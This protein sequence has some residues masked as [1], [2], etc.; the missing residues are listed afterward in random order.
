MGDAAHLH[1]GGAGHVGDVPGGGI[2]LYGGVGGE[3]Q[4]LDVL[5]LQAPLQDLQ[6]QLLGAY[7]VQR[8]Q[9][10]HQHEV[11]AGE[12]AGLLDGR[13]VCRA[14]HHAEQTVLLALGIGADLAAIVLGEGAAVAAMT[15]FGQRPIE[16]GGQTQ[17]AAALALQQGER[18]ALG[19]L[20]AH[21]RQDLQRLHH[22]IEQGTEFHGDIL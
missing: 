8:R 2:P 3:D 15:D 18:H 22:L 5:I 12:L 13:H 7:A 4:L 20:G 9:M 1:P 16:Q 10:A 11:A 6:P 14:L 21:A 17:T 19:R